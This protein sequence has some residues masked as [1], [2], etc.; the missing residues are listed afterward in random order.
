MAKLGGHVDLNQRTC[1]GRGEMDF[2]NGQLHG[3]GA[4]GEGGRGRRP[5]GRKKTGKCN[6]M[7]EK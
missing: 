1:G 5:T 2:G 4:K 7:T 3:K 6:V